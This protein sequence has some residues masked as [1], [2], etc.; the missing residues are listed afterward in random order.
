LKRSNSS[1]R[2]RAQRLGPGAVAKLLGIKRATL[3]Q[4][5]WAT[6][7]WTV[8][9]NGRRWTT[10]EDVQDARERHAI[11]ERLRSAA[12]LPASQSR[13]QASAD[14]KRFLEELNTISERAL[15]DDSGALDTIARQW[16]DSEP[17]IRS[18][19][20]LLQCDARRQQALTLLE[21]AARETYSYRRQSKAG[22][23]STAVRR[24]TSTRSAVIQHYARQGAKEARA[25]LRTLTFLGRQLYTERDPPQPYQEGSTGN[26]SS[27]HALEE[28]VEGRRDGFE[29]RPRYWTWV[30]LRTGR[31]ALQ[32][33]SDWIEQL[34]QIR[35]ALDALTVSVAGPRSHGTR[36]GRRPRPAFSAAQREIF[37]LLHAA[38][39]G[40]R[41][42][43]RLTGR[44][45]FVTGL[46]ATPSEAGVRRS[47]VRDSRKQR[48]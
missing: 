31:G 37:K 15:A 32:S 7:P 22:P 3:E 13:W 14:Y 42:A 36:G 46:Q 35:T 12:P 16:E 40:T 24:E 27:G 18:V 33:P 8:T 6:I 2:T 9:G 29:E 4:P 17:A 20:E 45:L 25:L 26:P 44:L 5:Q 34:E 48:A 21:R 30:H 10:R 28:L 39:A 23:E 47:S 11:S 43:A 41:A 38:K 19:Y 1:Q